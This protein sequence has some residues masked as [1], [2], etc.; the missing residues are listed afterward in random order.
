MSTK[1]T[2]AKGTEVPPEK[3][4]AEIE[5]ILRRYGATK[6]MSGWDDQRAAIMFEASGRRVKFMLPLPDPADF[7]WTE[8]GRRRTRDAQRAAHEAE[9]RRRWRALAL[10]IKAKL[11]VV[12]SGI[13]TFEDEF[14]AHIVLPNGATVGEWLGPQVERAYLTGDM[15]PMLPMLGSGEAG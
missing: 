1:G 6:F 4:K 5:T 3:S 13:S 12:E 10:A 2:Y 15:P 8:A 11:E 9:V 14:M 7:V